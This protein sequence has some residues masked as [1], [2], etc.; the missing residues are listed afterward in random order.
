MRLLGVILAAVFVGFGLIALIYDEPGYIL[1]NYAGWSIETALPVFIIILGLAYLIFY[2][3]SRVSSTIW[4]VKQRW[5]SWQLQR[6]RARAHAALENGLERIWEGDWIAAEK[7]LIKGAKDTTRPIYHYLSAAEAAQQQGALSRRDHYLKLAEKR[8]PEAHFTI[9]MKRAELLVTA[10]QFHEAL[11]ILQRLQPISHNNQQL[12]RL[13]AQVYYELQDW[14]HLTNALDQLRNYPVANEASFQRLQVEA[15][16]NFLAHCLLQ[17]DDLKVA[18][19][20]IRVPQKLRKHPV[21][22][23]LYVQNLLLQ[24]E[25]VQAEK[26]LSQAIKNRWNEELIVLYGLTQSPNGKKQLRTIENWI[27]KQPNNP[28][29]LQAAARVCVSNKL[30]GKAKNYYEASLAVQERHDTYKELGDLMEQM[31]DSQLA[32]ECYHKGLA[33]KVPQEIEIQID[34]QDRPVEKTLH[35]VKDELRGHLSRRLSG[36][37]SRVGGG[38]ITSAISDRLV[39]RLIGRGS[40]EG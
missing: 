15:Y 13:Y 25:M 3:I 9:N 10:G 33:L 34:S 7:L 39:D 19:A 30:W 20:W 16:A 23:P 29:L 35:P 22:L 8:M 4:F 37:S 6:H 11:A 5:G 32:A 27:Q 12:K 18:N 17:A 40:R 2:Y 36:S 24:G 1:I 38:G 14:D 28:H 26:L 31:G 21:I